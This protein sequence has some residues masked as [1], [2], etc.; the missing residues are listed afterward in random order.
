DRPQSCAAAPRP[1]R[2]GKRPPPGGT[3]S[4]ASPNS[5]PQRV[6]GLNVVRLA[7]LSD[8]HVTAPT[9]EWRLGDWFNKRLAAWI[10]FRWLGR[11][12][13]FRHS[14]TV[15]AA[16]AAELHARQPDHVVFSGDATALGFESEFRRATE[17]LDVGRRPGLAVPGNH[18]YCTR[19]AAASGLFERYFPPWQAGERIDGA[20]YPFAQR[21]GTAWLIGVNSC[22]GNRWAWDAGG[23]VGAEQL[24]RLGRLL[25]ALA[26]GPRIL[27]THY[28]IALASGKRERRVHGL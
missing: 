4:L 23:S 11:R 10:Y 18:D 27:V 7:H 1:P 25:G 20:I 26:P 14:D 16:F 5:I 15:M 13:R 9:L 12:H 6:P 19:P 8:I 2:S 17:Q 3:P 22:T 21:V 24:A 28:P